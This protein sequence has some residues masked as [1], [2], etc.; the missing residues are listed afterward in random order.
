MAPLSGLATK[1]AVAEAKNASDGPHNH[2]L[3]LSAAPLQNMQNFKEAAMAVGS[4][5]CEL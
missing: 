4:L 1:L 3:T 2:S 5:T